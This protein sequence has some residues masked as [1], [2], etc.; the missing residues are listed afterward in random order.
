[1]IRIAAILLPALVTNTFALAQSLPP[2]DALPLSEVMAALEEREPVRAI[3]EVEWDS[4]G[5][6][7]VEYVDTSGRE[8]EIRLDPA[9]AANLQR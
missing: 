8:I 1:M 6:W 4:D 3:L 9:T 5:H 2:E 7:E